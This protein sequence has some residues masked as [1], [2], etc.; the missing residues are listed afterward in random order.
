VSI[1][2]TLGL[3]ALVASGLTF[4]LLYAY[5]QYMSSSIAAARDTL[6]ASEKQFE[7]D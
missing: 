3:L 5:A 7:P 1:L 6:A 2:G 4:G